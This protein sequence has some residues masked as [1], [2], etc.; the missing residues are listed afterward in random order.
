MLCISFNSIENGHD[1]LAM[2]N[3]FS[4]KGAHSI[5]CFEIT[6]NFLKLAFVGDRREAKFPFN[7]CWNGRMLFEY[8]MSGHIA[9]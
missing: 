9:K 6:K 1:C 8:E 2:Y 3:R 7:K 5:E 4:D